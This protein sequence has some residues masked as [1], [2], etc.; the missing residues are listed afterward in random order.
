MRLNGHLLHTL[1]L[2]ASVGCCIPC[3][4]VQKAID[5]GDM[6][7]L[8][9]LLKSGASPNNYTC[10]CEVPVSFAARLCN[11]DALRQLIDAGAST[12]NTWA[13]L[14]LRNSIQARC[15]TEVVG[16]LLDAGV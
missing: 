5:K 11:K 15:G 4:R 14:A 13:E 8:E 10:A 3:G 12:T 16:L 2:L 1:L 9:Q 6:V 7:R